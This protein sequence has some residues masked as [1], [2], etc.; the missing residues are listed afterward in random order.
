MRAHGQ[1]GPG[2]GQGRLQLAQLLPG[3]A[4]QHGQ[5]GARRHDA[6]V[7]AVTQRPGHEEVARLLEPGQRPDLGGLALDVGVAGLPVDRFRPVGLQHLVGLV[8]AGRLHIDDEG[9]VGVQLRQVAGQHQADLVG[10]DLLAGVVHHPAAVAVAVEAQRQIGP[11]LPHALRHLAQHG[12]VLGVGVVLGEGEVEVGVHLDHLGSHAAQGFRREGPGRAVS[13]GGDHL[14]RP[15]QLHLAHLLEVALAEVL[16]AGQ[17][18]AAPRLT[19]AAQHDVLQPAD[20]VGAEGQRRIGP[21]LDPGPAILVVAG[22]DHGH[23]RSVQRELGEIGHRRQGQADVQHFHAAFQQAEGQGLLHRQGIGAEVVADHD[24]RPLADL[25]D[26]GR[27]AQAQRLHAQQVDLLLQH[28]ARVVLPEAGRLDQR[29][30][31]VGGGVRAKIGAGLEHGS[32][33]L[34]GPVRPSWP[35]FLPPLVRSRNNAPPAARL[36]GTPRRAEA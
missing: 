32:S 23:A 9:R 13:A 14:D 35:R 12:V 28:P 26:V 34:A 6:V 20:L 29:G 2:V 31:L 15:A 33:C 24:A 16:D 27:Q 22:G 5:H 4:V 25:V 10:E 21:H 18:P 1:A 17:R 11:G 36:P 7:V 19:L 8:E 3:I 30:G